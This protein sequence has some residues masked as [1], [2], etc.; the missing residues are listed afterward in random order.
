MTEYLPD[1][2]FA[3]AEAV[4]TIAEQDGTPF[5]LYHKDGLLE[6][7]KEL[8]DAFS[9]FPGYQNYFNIRENN[10]PEILKILFAAGTGVCACSHTELLLAEACGFHGEQLLYEPSRR[11]SQGEAL[12][13]KLQATWLINSAFLLPDTLPERIILRYHA[14]QERMSAV[15]F[16]KIKNSKNG[17]DRKHI[18]A[19]LAEL[20]QKGVAKLGVALQ[21]ASYSIHPGFWEKKAKLLL[22]LAQEVR[23]QFG[24]DLWCLHM[25]EGPGLPYRPRETAPE[26]STEAEQVRKSLENMDNPPLIFTGVNRHLMEHHGILVTKVLEQRRTYK[27]FLILDAGISHYI[28]AVLKQAYRHVSVLGKCD[29]ENRQQYFLCGELPD[30][31]DHLSKEGRMLP[32]VTPGEY[33]VLHDVGCG[34]RSMSMLYGCQRM[35]GEYLLESDGTIRSIAP[36]R[37][38]REILRFLTA[39]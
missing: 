5:Y 9:R 19:L 38:E 31:I 10:N 33:C 18:L 26:L 12:A 2:I 23:K 6:S 13:Q 21:V 3:P 14:S 28:R 4:R 27:N 24:F 34:G 17:L 1:R 35:A 39:W 37:D 30:E 22:T 11:D 16:S 7:V 25:G 36:G 32:N 29:M 15:K 20:R 8:H